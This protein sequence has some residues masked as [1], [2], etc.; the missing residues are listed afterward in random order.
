VEVDRIFTALR[1]CFAGKASVVYFFMG[2][3]DLA[4]TRKGVPVPLAA[5]IFAPIEIA[6]VLQ[7]RQFSEPQRPGESVVVSLL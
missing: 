2:S 6:L 4:V 7:S 5:A 3:F 1:A